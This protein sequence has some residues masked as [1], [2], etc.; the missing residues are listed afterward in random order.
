MA[1]YYTAIDSNDYQ[2]SD[3]AAEVFNAISRPAANGDK[4]PI[5]AQNIVFVCHSLGG[6][7]TR[8]M[9]ESRSADFADKSIGIVLMASPSMGSTYA[10]TFKLLIRFYKNKLGEQLQLM[11]D[12]LRDLDSR[13]RNLLDAKHTSIVG[14][15]A[16]EHKALF[17]WSWLPPLRPIVESW[18][19]SR[20][21][22]NGR[23]LAGTNHST[24]VKPD[25]VEHPSHTFLIDFFNHKFNGTIQKGH[26]LIIRHPLV[27]GGANQLSDDAKKLALF[28]ILGKENIPYYLRRSFDNDLQTYLD[29]YSVWVS[30]PSG[31][32]KTSAI[33]YLL[34]TRNHKPLDICLSHCGEHFTR[35]DFIKEIMATANQ[36]ELLGRSDRPMTYHDLVT[37]FSEYSVVSSIV[38]HLDEIPV[39]N[40][41]TTSVS[42]LLNLISDLLSSVKQRANRSDLRIVISSIYE[43]NTS[44]K[45]NREKLAEQLKIVAISSWSK[46]DLS[47]LLDLII[48]SV[49]KIILIGNEKQ[50]LIDAC[51]GSPRFLKNFLRDW[52]ATPMTEKDFF[53]TLDAAKKNAKS[54]L[55]FL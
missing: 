50:K 6:I 25:S 17:G 31:S 29:L 32:G 48:R 15:E 26:P 45:G 22:G 14:A 12:S 30:G 42:E 24:I 55:I 41:G 23:T 2:I 46:P 36:L 53:E 44:I 54:E 28:D 51:N 52:L 20:Y 3:C 47:N 38:L 37:L 43:P 27:D 7:V 19:A 49:P 1:G 21:F 9:L 11:N 8:Y 10:D 40:E 4:A 39:S 16:I 34:E 33:R 35:D 5:N 13:F 18:S